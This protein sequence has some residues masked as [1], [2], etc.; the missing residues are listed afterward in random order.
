[1]QTDNQTERRADKTK[2]IGNIYGFAKAP[3]SPGIKSAKEMQCYLMLQQ[4]RL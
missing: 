2:L 4:S 1:M 3:K